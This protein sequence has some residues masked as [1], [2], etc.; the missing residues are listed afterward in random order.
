MSDLAVLQLLDEARIGRVLLHYATLLDQRRWA[1]LDEVFTPDAVAVYHGIGRFEGL[2]AI[3]GVIK[4]FLELCG[5]TQHMITNIRV[6]P[7]GHQASA[8]CYLQATHAGRGTYVGKTM[9]VWG[10]YTDH[11]EQGAEGWRIVL[12]ELVVQHVAGDVGV[13]LKG[14]A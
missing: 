9:T 6:T 7:D 3:T 13:A 4:G 11:L 8:R 14:S 12:R 1:A 10:E 2:P 5:P